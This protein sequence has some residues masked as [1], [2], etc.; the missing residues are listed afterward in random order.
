VEFEPMTQSR[1]N[2]LAFAGLAPL[3]VVMAHTAR[4]ASVCN[5]PASLSL[6]QKN[7]RRGLGYVEVA[8]DPKKHCGLCAFFTA[9][10]GSC[11]NCQMMSG[12]PVDA[13]SVCN[14]FAPKV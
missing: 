5:D 12:A 10:E 14:S 1:R 6:A 13:A 4:A 8:P 9:H 7:M 11:G 3:A 2:F